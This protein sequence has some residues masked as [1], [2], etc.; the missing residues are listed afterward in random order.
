MVEQTHHPSTY[1]DLKFKASLGCILRPA[2]NG[3]L[4]MPGALSHNRLRKTPDFS[5]FLSSIK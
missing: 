1:E 4:E 3:N 2:S 5:F